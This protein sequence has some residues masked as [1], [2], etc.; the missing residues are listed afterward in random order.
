M[1]NCL[2]SFYLGSEL[3]LIDVRRPCHLD[4]LCDPEDSIVATTTF[5]CTWLTCIGCCMQLKRGLLATPRTGPP[6]NFT[7][8][9]MR[10]TYGQE[11]ETW[12]TDEQIL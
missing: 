8:G 3:I 4:T 6:A 5:L 9:V 2:L 1:L 12:G 10:S 11:E 7:W